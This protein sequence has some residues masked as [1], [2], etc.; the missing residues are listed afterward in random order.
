M[1][2]FDSKFY[3]NMM[4]SKDIGFHNSDCSQ[5][6]SNCNTFEAFTYMFKT[7]GIE[8]QTILLILVFGTIAC[9]KYLPASFFDTLNIQ[10]LLI[11]LILISFVY[12][13]MIGWSINA[14][15]Y[16]ANNKGDYS[17]PQFD[18]LKSFITIFK[19]GIA[20]FLFAVSILICGFFI[21]VITSM[22][23]Q[24]LPLTI[25][26]C[27]ILLIYFYYILIAFLAVFAHTQKLTIFFEFAKINR[28]IKRSNGKY[29]KH[30]IALLLCCISIG[31]ASIPFIL[32]FI[33]ME[34]KTFTSFWPILVHALCNTYLTYVTIY[35]AAKCL[36]NTDIHTEFA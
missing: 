24:L 9:S 32:P 13:C 8:L 3:Q 26:A 6:D 35:I 23:P 16:I 2:T 12:P 20:V 21:M 1:Y 15:N 29:F 30:I 18:L 4:K 34:T 11:L 27:I 10:T 36:N 25:I 22:I 19:F 17:L 33:N 31:I 5:E 7:K 28:V 14:I